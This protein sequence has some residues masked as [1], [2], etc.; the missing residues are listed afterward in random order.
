[1]NVSD[2]IVPFLI[3]VILMPFDMIA[4]IKLIDPLIFIFERFNEIPFN[5]QE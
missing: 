5:P 3:P 1:M 2:F 4:V